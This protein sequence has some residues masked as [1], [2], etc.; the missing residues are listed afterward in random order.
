MNRNWLWIILA[1]LITLPGL[2]V[3]AMGIHLTPLEMAVIFGFA[4]LG[5]AF[6]ISW[7]A[8]VAETEVSQ[9]LALAALALIAVLPEYSVD[10]Y[11]AWTAA[12]KPEYT[13]YAAANMTG[14]NR[15]LIGFGWSLVVILYW[16]R[17]RKPGIVLH[18]SMSIELSFLILATIYSFILPLKGTIDLIDAVILVGLFILYIWRAGTAE[19]EEVELFGPAAV[20]GALPR[21][22][23]I[24]AAIFFFAFSG[25]VIFLSA[26]PFA[27]G[28]IQS[29]RLAGIDEFILVQ[30]L[31]PLASEAPE[32][33][34]ATV[35]TW[36]LLATNAIGALISSKVN[37][38]TL[39]IGCLPIAYSIS[40]LRFGALA[41]DARQI[42][43]ILLTAAQS[44]FAI[45]ILVNLD[46]SLK[47]ALLLLV[48]FATQLIFPDPTFRFIYS[49]LYIILTI[50]ILATDRQRLPAAWRA[51]RRDVLGGQRNGGA[52]SSKAGN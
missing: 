29:G 40:G 36:R 25:A 44:L 43:E 9:S 24:L 8:E 4:I 45:A 7:G 22:W 2:Y 19:V 13:A 39:L 35:F 11:F 10:I 46:M 51:I 14:A 15:L 6:L 1:F 21:V 50:I 3:R 48:L 23:K 49:G 20:V 34:V 17:T 16:L 38:W 26:E 31:A 52:H 27:E 18:H 30:W 5:A 33:F 42:E 37:Q 12:H 32:I 47:E 28:L 41:L